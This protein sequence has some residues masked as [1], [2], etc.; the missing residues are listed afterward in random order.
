MRG[1]GEDQ[2]ADAGFSNPFEIRVDR[3]STQYTL[4]PRPL[5]V[6]IKLWI[7]VNDV[8]CDDELLLLDATTQEQQPSNGRAA[9]AQKVSSSELYNVAFAL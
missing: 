5:R 1:D 3:L 6:R 8:M 2:S 9:D 7:F 4:L